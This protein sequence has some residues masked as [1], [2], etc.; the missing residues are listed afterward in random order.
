M[1]PALYGQADPTSVVLQKLVRD[2]NGNIVEEVPPE[3]TFSVFLNGNTKKVLIDNAPRWDGIE[4]NI[5][6]HGTFSVEL[7]NFPNLGEGDTATVRFTDNILSQQGTFSVVINTIPWSDPNPFGA[8]ELKNKSFPSAPDSIRYSLSGDGFPRLE[9]KITEGIQYM[10]YRRVFQDRLINGDSRFLYT[11]IADS[12]NTGSFTDTSVD[13]DKNYG[14]IIYAKDS[15]GKIS[16]HSVDPSLDFDECFTLSGWNREGCKAM[17][18]D[19]LYNNGLAKT[20]PMGWN[21]WNKFGCNINAD[22][23]KSTADAMVKSGMKDAGYQYIN[24]DDCWMA[25]SRDAQ[26]KLQA[27][28]IRFPNG[29]KA[30]ADYVHSKGLKIGIYSSAGTL[31]CQG[32]PASLD[33]EQIDAQTFADWGIDYLKYDN[34]NNQGR[35]AKTRYKTMSDALLS[36]DQPIVYSICE[37]GQN[38]PWKWAPSMGN[39]WR[40]TGDIWG[41]WAKNGNG[42]QNSVLLILDKQTNLFPYAGPGHW[43]DPDMLE[44]G[45]GSLT[46]TESKA[47]FSLW[48]MLAA[49]LIAGN[50]LRNMPNDV[51]KILTDKDLITIDQDSLGI[52]GRKIRDDGEIEIWARP[53]INN[54]VAVLLLNR[55]SQPA[56][57]KTDIDEIGFHAYPNNNSDYVLRNL[58]AQTETTTSGNIESTVPSHGA[59]VFK[60]GSKSDVA[61]DENEEKPRHYS[62][63]PNYPNPFNPVTQI[64]FTLPVMQKVTLTIYD[65]TGRKVKTLVNAV[66][67][68]GSYQETFDGNHLASGV[69]LY[70]LKTGGFQ[71][72]RKMMLIK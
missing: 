10:V 8:L 13:P 50:D 17:E 7:G 3:A 26:G 59:T 70:Q 42:A 22:L 56:T 62:L 2:A 41:E 30:V 71:K 57:I 60:V 29:I 64:R 12:I 48:A 58:W 47:H 16:S 5:D 27:D 65:I 61:I 28:P 49:P 54:Q 33:H 14:Y 24:I 9:W 63:K 43:N 45:N 18:P 4:T 44:V 53:L 15:N 34:C 46:I 69:Y 66:L 11:L 35:P 51:N 23:I 40:T 68:A 55:G 21:S 19:N 6:G 72:V 67:P 31:T 38:D 32:L 1:S 37:W 52:Q 20:P 39:L 36:V 25:S